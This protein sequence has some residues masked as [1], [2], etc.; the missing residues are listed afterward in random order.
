MENGNPRTLTALDI[1]STD[2]ITD[3]TLHKFI[4]RHG[5]QLHACILSGMTHITDQLWMSVLPILQNA[6]YTNKSNKNDCT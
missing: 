2:N 6:K 5:G 3:E 4:S 1:D